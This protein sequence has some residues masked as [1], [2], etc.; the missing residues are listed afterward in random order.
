MRAQE[1]PTSISKSPAH[2]WQGLMPGLEK[3][4]LRFPVP[5]RWA[6]VKDDFRSMHNLI[7][8]HVT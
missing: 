1:L 5:S 4:V 8:G 3:S 6:G 7:V 2:R